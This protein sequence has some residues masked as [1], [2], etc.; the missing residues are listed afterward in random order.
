MNNNHEDA[1]L[2]LEDEKNQTEMQ[3]QNQVI[4]LQK[5]NQVMMQQLD[6]KEK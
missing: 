4:Q 1:Y 2:A 6:S 5:E 3:M